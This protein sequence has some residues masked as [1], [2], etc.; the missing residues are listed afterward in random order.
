M[1]DV[2]CDLT[3][4]REEYE[5]K[6]S[7]QSVEAGNLRCSQPGNVCCPGDAG[8]VAARFYSFSI[9]PAGGF[10][11]LDLPAKFPTIK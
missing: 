10:F 5:E 3:S 1:H 7:S 2:S 9:A 8:S 11:S 6:N 4:S